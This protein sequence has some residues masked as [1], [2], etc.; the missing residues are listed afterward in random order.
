MKKAQAEI[1]NV[2]KYLKM[3]LSMSSMYVMKNGIMAKISLKQQPRRRRK[4]NGVMKAAHQR[5]SVSSAAYQWRKR[6]AKSWR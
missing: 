5:R 4:R 2:R 1:I 6:K 3:A